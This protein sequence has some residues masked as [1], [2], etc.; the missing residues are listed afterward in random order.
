MH[1]QYKNSGISYANMA[2][3]TSELSVLAMIFVELVLLVSI[4]VR[5]F[6]KGYSVTAIGT[7]A[8]E[9]TNVADRVTLVGDNSGK[10][11]R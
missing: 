9:W 10:N 4:S 5:I 11:L 7:N 8:A 2:I 6:K 3:G 1:R